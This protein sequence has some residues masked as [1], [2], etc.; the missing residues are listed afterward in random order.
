MSRILFRAL[1]AG[2][3]LSAVRSIAQP[4][5][6]GLEFRV[7][8]YTTSVQHHPVVADQGTGFVV[9]WD[10]PEASDDGGI[11]AQLYDAVGAVGGEFS[12]NSTTSGFQTYPSVASA[13]SAFVVVWQSPDS[14]GLTDVFGQRFDSAGSPIGP[15]F[16][17]N[18]ST[19]GIQ[20]QAKVQMNPKQ[21]SFVVVWASFVV[22]GAAGTDVFAQR[23]DAVGAPLGSNFVVNTYTTGVQNHPA[24]AVTQFGDFLVAWEGSEPTD[25]TGIWARRYSSAGAPQGAEFRVNTVT[26]GTQGTVDVSVDGVGDYLVVWQ[27]IGSGNADVVAQ[28]LG[29]AGNAIGGEVLVNGFTTNTQGS[30]SVTFN[31]AASFVAVWQ[32]A[33]FSEIAIAGRRLVGGVTKGPDF[34]VNSYTTGLRDS[35]SVTR[36]DA[37]NFVVVWEGEGSGDDSGVFARRFCF[38]NGDVDFDGVIGVAD[39]FYL[40]NALFAGGPA[41]IQSGNANG[42]LTTDVNDVFYLINYLFAGGPAPVCL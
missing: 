35:P 22:G 18:S 42:D 27:S 20:S 41:P 5:P 26:T 23:Y 11:H 28:R 37:R 16:R 33:P 8:T 17:V 29:L 38:P 2:V 12:V 25:S 19:T 10:G 4:L 24:V 34:Q 6:V 32:N 7:N 30:P 21:G 13:G 40:I 3:F 36:I 9:V 1:A 14:G 31:S 39:I 15:E